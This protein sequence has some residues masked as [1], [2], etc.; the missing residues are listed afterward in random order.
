MTNG[1]RL[2]TKRN[3]ELEPFQKDFEKIWDTEGIM[4]KTRLFA[5]GTH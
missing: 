2:Y 4:T 1:S 5:E 3:Q